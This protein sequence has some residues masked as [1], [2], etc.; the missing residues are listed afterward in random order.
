MDFEWDFHGVEWTFNGSY[1]DIA[2]WDVS[3]WCTYPS[4]K[5]WSSSIGMMTFPTEWKNTTCS[6]P[7]TLYETWVSVKMRD[8]PPIYG[9]LDDEAVDGMGYPPQTYPYDVMSGFFFQ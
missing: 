7:P 9:K 2:I 3:G 5:W 1:W 4:E 8:W 6:K